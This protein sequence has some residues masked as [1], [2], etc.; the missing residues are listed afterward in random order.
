MKDVDVYVLN[1][2][3]IDDNILDCQIQLSLYCNYNCPYC[4]QHTNENF[5]AINR[6][7]IMKIIKFLKLQNFDKLELT[8]TGGEPTLNKDLEY[9]IN[10]FKKEFE[11]IHICVISNLTAPISTYL[12][13]DIDEYLISYHSEFIKSPASWVKK[14]RNILTNGKVSPDNINVALMYH[15]NNSDLIEQMYNKY[16]NILP[17]NT[18]FANIHTEEELIFSKSKDDIANE[19]IRYNTKD[20]LSKMILKGK[21]IS[22]ENYFNYRNFKGM[23]CGTGFIISP[24]LKV[25]K[26]WQEYGLGKVIFDL[27][28]QAPKYIQRWFLCTYNKE[29]CDGFHYPKYSLNYFTKH[30]KKI[31]KYG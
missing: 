9:Y 27:V 5:S 6:H 11:Y 4:T 12:N 29:C 28:K 17:K 15:R 20:N 26:C 23:I 22:K 18:H 1:K 30:N 21:C 24:D 2:K 10:L 8:F 31:T 3:I 14:L 25:Y 13:L 7:S 16:K 19:I